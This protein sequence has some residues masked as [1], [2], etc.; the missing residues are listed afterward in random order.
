MPGGR[1][2]KPRQIKIIHHTF[3]KDRNPG[4]EPE[5][6]P[7]AAV[8]KPPLGLNRWARQEWKRLAPDLVEQALLTSLDL[9]TLEI[10][11]RL[12]GLSR[13]AEE[14]IYH[15]RDPQTGRRGR[16]TL[17]QYLAGRNSQTTPELATARSAWSLYRSYLVEF[18]LS[19]A[20]RNRIHLPE[21]KGAG[22]D[23]MEELLRG[24]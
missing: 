12:Y 2:R 14:A 6:P 20:S 19:P 5:P 7:V 22:E 15:P 10:A 23:P 16:R 17:Q 18:G 1:P 3:R 21:S 13:E 9:T 24:T 11:C 8:P 4:R